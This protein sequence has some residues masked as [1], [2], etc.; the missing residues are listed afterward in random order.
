VSVKSDVEGESLVDASVV[1]VEAPR[2]STWLVVGALLTAFATVVGLGA[3]ASL[4]PHHPLW[5]IAL[6]PLPRHLILVAPHTPLVPFVAVA[7]LRGLFGCLVAF[8]LGRFYG[9][10]GFP[11]IDEVKNPRANRM[12]RAVAKSFERWSQVLLLVFPGVMT[13]GLAGAGGL[14]R[15]R[16]LIATA[17]GLVVWALINHHVGG[18]LAPW[19]APILR[20]I[21]ENMRTATLVC[22]GIAALYYLQQRRTF[23]G[24]DP[25]KSE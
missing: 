15:T 24:D 8:E 18:L 19:T 16:S 25:P 9:P 23:R 1:S 20:F 11:S 13:S 22:V 4:A 6:N 17:I 7:V 21:E 5:L 3:V 12:F 14:S 10:Q 2:P